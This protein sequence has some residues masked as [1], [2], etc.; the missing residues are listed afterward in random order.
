MGTLE[1][2]DI[3]FGKIDGYNEFLEYG[4]DTCKGLFFEFPNVDISKLLNGSIYYIFGNKGT[5][6]TML[7]KY[8]E[9]KVLENKAEIF[10]QFI[11]FKRDVGEEERNQIKR[12]ALPTN[13]F[14][15]VIDSEIPT[16]CTL[17]CSLVW[18]VYLIKVIVA[19]LKEA[20]YG[21]FD[22][23]DSTWKELCA[24]LD[25]V[26]GNNYRNSNVKTILPKMK[27]GS[28]ELDISKVGK[29]SLEFEWSDSSKRMISFSELGKHIISLYTRLVPVE[30]KIYIFIDELELAFKQSKKYQRDVTLIRDLIFAIEYLSDINRTREFN[31]YI[32]TAIRTEV[33]KNII[34]K[35]MEINKT[36]HDF[37]VTIS[38]EQ[39]GGNIKNHPLL[40]MLEKRIHFSEEIAGIS[41]S[42]D[43][44]ETYFIPY[45]GNSRVEVQNYILNQT[46]YKPRDIIRFFTVIQRLY[47]QKT[48]IDQ[49]CFDSARKPYAEESWS[50]FEEFL[51]VKY[52]DCEVEGIKKALTGIQLPFA[53]SDFQRRLNEKKDFFEEV[54]VLMKKRSTP[55]ILMDLY[56][57]GIIGNYGPNS[58]FAFKG[59]DDIDP[60][61]P[62][63][64]HYPLIRFFKASITSFENK[65]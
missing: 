10:S 55:N 62:I 46:W 1:L 34:S 48:L 23:D 42:E 40:K 56:D 32:I 30:D 36:I 22:R 24:V 58:R 33:Y 65:K 63:T 15:E 52:T 17:D 51:T 31:V 64:I 35:G 18:Q 4:Q 47:G 37:G 13:A 44:W 25:A 26:Y 29:T 11:R 57:I 59:D 7:L 8:L 38:W 5:G 41:Q 14:E 21:V 60:M 27:R 20:E 9:S 28:V 6:K 43:I 12:A 53:V 45:V 2:K 3:Y 16:D 50:E 39:K 19:R 54:H 61:M 49:E